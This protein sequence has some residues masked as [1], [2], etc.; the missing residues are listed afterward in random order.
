MK[1]IFKILSGVALSVLLFASCNVENIK[2]TYSPVEASEVSFAQSVITNQEIEA[3]QSSFDI[4]ITRNTSAAA[5]TVPVKATLPAGITCPE[6]VSFEAGSYS[7]TLSLDISAMAIGKSYK[8]TIALSDSTTFNSHI[9]VAST[10]FTL[11]KAYTWV[12][13]GKATFS[14]AFMFENSYQCEIKKADGFDRYSLMDPYSEGLVAEDYGD[15]AGTPCDYIEFYVE[16]VSDIDLVFWSPF[17]VGY[18]YGKSSSTPVYAYHPSAFSSMQ[19]PAAWLHSKPITG[20]FQLAP[21]YYIS[22][23]GGWNYTQ[24]DKIILIML[25]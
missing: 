19:D 14:D 3:R 20:G 5:I 2:D 9:A 25:P 24:E 22:G 12:S 13:L 21:Y 15:Y 1:N 18:N 4:N 8:G 11:A 17:A 10:S 16:K 23:V 6:S 7:T